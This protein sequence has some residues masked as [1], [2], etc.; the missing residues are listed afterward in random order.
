MELNQL[1][2]KLEELLELIPAYEKSKSILDFYKKEADN[3]GKKIKSIM[4]A[5]GLETFIVG[6]TKATVKVSEKNNFNEEALIAK[7]K[8]LGVPGIIKK[9]EY[10]D[11][12]ALENALYHEKINAIDLANCQIKKEIVTLRLSAINK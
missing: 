8:E 6:N 7:L 1:N 11:M 5:E 4:L 3:S 2:P 10:V 12:D 9:K